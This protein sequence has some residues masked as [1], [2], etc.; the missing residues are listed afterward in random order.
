[1]ELKFI[2]ESLLFASQKPL[3]ARELKEIL[4]QAVEQTEDPAPKAFRKTKED[5]ITAALEQLEKEHAEAARSYRLVCVAGSWQF[6]SLPEY[7]P[8]LRALVGEKNRPPRLSQPSL[9][10]LAIIAYRQPLTR[11]EIEQIRGVSVDG[12]MQTLLERGLIEQIGRAEV[13]GRPM[14]YGT[15]ALF[16]EYFGLRNLEDLPAADELR[17]I[18]VK[19]PESLLTVEPG[20]ATAPPDQLT[21]EN[22]TAEGEAASGSSTSG[23]SNAPASAESKPATPGNAS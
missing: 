21:S 14:T 8:W 4:A 10:T 16:L 7:A 1:M 17:R 22:A 15:T 19:R 23:T 9:E 12:V 18:P 20:L 3:S 13:V 11:A 5:D 2:L 6:V